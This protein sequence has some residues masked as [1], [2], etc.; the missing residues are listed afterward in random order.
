M[1][2]YS[3]GEKEKAVSER[4]SEAWK[5]DHIDKFL[6]IP[7]FILGFLCIHP[8]NDGNGR[9]SRLLTLLLFYKVGYIVWKYI[10]VEMLIEKPK[11]PIMKH[12]RQAQ[13]AGIKMRTATNL[14]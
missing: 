8:F 7:M 11:K 4:I 2:I 9:M 14:L 13:P 5:A 12:C 1:E 10:S 3:F 6:L